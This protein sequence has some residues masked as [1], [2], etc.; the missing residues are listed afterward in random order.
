MAVDMLVPL[1]TKLTP[2]VLSVAALH[3]CHSLR[4]E[5]VTSSTMLAVLGGHGRLKI[6]MTFRLRI[7]KGRA[8]GPLGGLSR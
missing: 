1:R 7:L 6:A 5:K 2:A 8:S 3:R 4:S